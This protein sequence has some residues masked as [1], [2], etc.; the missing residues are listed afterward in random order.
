MYQFPAVKA[1]IRYK[2]QQRQGGGETLPQKY[3]T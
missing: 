3:R 2:V 1:G